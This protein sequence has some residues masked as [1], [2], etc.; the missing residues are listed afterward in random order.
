VNRKKN[1]TKKEG[2][3]YDLKA[4]STVRGGMLPRQRLKREKSVPHPRRTSSSA[5][6]IHQVEYSRTNK[7]GR[8]KISKGKR[9][10]MLY[11][12]RKDKGNIH[13][14]SNRK[15]PTFVLVACCKEG[16]GSPGTS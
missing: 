10:S 4:E 5:T 9:D 6:T 8:G 12:S 1:K 2:G 15:M 3:T 16:A 11:H 14:N 7:R 13:T